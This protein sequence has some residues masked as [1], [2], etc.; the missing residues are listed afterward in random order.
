MMTAVVMT[1]VMVLVAEVVLVVVAEVAV[2]V[3]AVVVLVM[4]LMV[5][6]VVAFV[7]ATDRRTMSVLTRILKR[8]STPSTTHPTLLSIGLSM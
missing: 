4:A 1:V 7:D 3:V 8:F 6:C 5:V 2:V